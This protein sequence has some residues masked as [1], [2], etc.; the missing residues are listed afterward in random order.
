M[1]D[2]G[3]VHSRGLEC[4]YND[5]F[6]D[7]QVIRFHLIYISIYF[8]W[9]RKTFIWEPSDTEG[10]GGSMLSNFVGDINLWKCTKFHRD[11]TC[12]DQDI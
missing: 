7:L 10:L 6:R 12:F 1:T 3:P 9:G 11:W 2:E 8:V 5:K 4:S